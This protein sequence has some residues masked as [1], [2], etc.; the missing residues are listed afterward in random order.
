L[1]RS[2]GLLN[3][4]TL[5]TRWINAGKYRDS[6]RSCRVHDEDIQERA[7]SA[8]EPPDDADD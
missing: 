2:D 3:N 1:G 6:V 5:N 7:R 4:G 8:G